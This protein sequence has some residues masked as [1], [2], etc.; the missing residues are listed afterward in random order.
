MVWTYW[1]HYNLQGI[2]FKWKTSVMQRFNPFLAAYIHFQPVEC[3][4]MVLIVNLKHKTAKAN[5]L[6]YQK[7]Y[8]LAEIQASLY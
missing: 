4:I 5:R 7:M 8:L 2:I 1:Q 6:R 3:F